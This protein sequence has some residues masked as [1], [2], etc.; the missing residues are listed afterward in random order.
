MR[1]HL[2]IVKPVWNRLSLKEKMKQIYYLNCM[3]LFES[4]KW[5]K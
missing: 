4:P 1:M 3:A 2:K 5:M